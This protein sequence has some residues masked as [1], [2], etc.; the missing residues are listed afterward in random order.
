MVQCVLDIRLVLVVL[1]GLE[2]VVV[3]VGILVQVDK[4]D[5]FVLKIK[6]N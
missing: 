6:T 4:M 2:V 3:V 5:K 1:A